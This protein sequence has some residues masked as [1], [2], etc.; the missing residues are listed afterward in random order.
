MAAG[1]PRPVVFLHG[2][3]MR[4]DIFA[5]QIARQPPHL[6][7]HPPALP[8]HGAAR[9]WPLSMDGAADCLASHLGRHDLRG[10]VLVGWSMGATVAWRYLARH[11]ADRIAGLVSVDMSPRLLNGPDWSL[12]LRGQ[13]AGS[14]RTKVAWFRHSWRDAA[15]SIAAGMFGARGD[16]A[17]LPRADAVARVAA[18]DGAVMAEVWASLIEADARATV[19]G[20]PVP[21]LVLHG[22]QSRV[23]T[24][25]TAAWLATAAPRATCRCFAA[26]GHAPHLEE[27]AAFASTLHAFADTL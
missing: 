13:D 10:A 23:Y 12:G 16:S 2:W 11:G 17:L 24:P 7:G 26:S 25:A 4:G 15:Q 19:R 14:A 5:D 22:A 3:T 27:P 9:G 21:M 1:V 8:G 18:N 20:L 6:A